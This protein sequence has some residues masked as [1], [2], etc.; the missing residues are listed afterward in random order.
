MSRFLL[1]WVKNWLNRRAQRVVVNGARSGWW[2]VTSDV[3]QGSIAGPVLF[4]IF[5]NDLDAF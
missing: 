4:N 3:P 5:I 2:P 1:H